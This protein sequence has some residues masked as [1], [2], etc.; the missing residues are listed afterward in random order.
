MNAISKTQIFFDE[1]RQSVRLS[2]P[3]M[4][5]NIVQASSGFLGTVMV[6]HLGRNALGAMALGSSVYFTLIVFLFGVLS[7]VGVV[8]AQNYGAKN[9][10]GMELAFAQGAILALS[11][12]IPIMLI[13]WFSPYIL[14]WSGEP[15]PIIQLTAQYLH[16][17][18]WCVVPLSSLVVMEQFLIGMSRTRL[19]LWVSL[20]EVP[21][22]ILA[23]YALVFGKFGMPKCGIAGAGYGFAIV[24]TVTALGLALFLCG[25]K[26]YRKYRLFIR[27][28]NFNAKYFVELLRVGWPIGCM[29]VVEVALLSALAFLMGKVSGD[30]LAANRI[31]RQFLMLG[32]MFIF[33]I[34]QVT[35][36]RVGQAVGRQDRP[37][38]NQAIFANL[39]FSSCIAVLVSVCYVIFARDFVGLD[40]N[41]TD[42][43]LAQL[44]H[45]A[46][47]FL[48][49]AGIAQVFDNL[50]F[51]A[52]GALRGVKDTR[53]PMYIS[54]ITFWLVAL[55]VAIVLCFAV[56]LG[57]VGLWI[58]L[59]AGIV[60]GAV[61]LLWRC[62]KLVNKV[63]LD[64]LLV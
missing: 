64:K 49:F 37:G 1:V 54:M 50:R 46:I 61:I 58:G 63:E 48:A 12:C 31:A 16:A 18:F 52:I 28:L 62:W 30:A 23:I 10:D 51:I 2:L 55:P 44:T 13:L 15:Q 26:L 5:S 24:F 43:A 47:I 36:V 42:P 27:L 11:S 25:S 60:S 17:L 45:Y 41:I 8:V 34:S 53:V 57:G 22:E 4:T 56:H 39:A 6:A 59:L 14:L 7:S 20:C 38:I 9:Q 35:T 40:V 33:A 3:L 21:F 19:V 29:Y 32:M